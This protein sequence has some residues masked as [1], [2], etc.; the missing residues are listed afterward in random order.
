VQTV[1]AEIAVDSVQLEAARIASNATLLFEHC[2]AGKPL[3]DKLISRADTR[4]TGP[5]DDYVR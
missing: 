5:E 4:R 1:A 3:F 2:D